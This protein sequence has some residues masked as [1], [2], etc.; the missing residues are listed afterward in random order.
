MASSSLSRTLGT[1]TDTKKWTNS[2]WWKPAIG[3]SQ[4]QIFNV[5]NGTADNTF[6]LVQYR[7]NAEIRLNGYNTTWLTTNRKFRDYSAWYHVVVVADSTES[8]ASNRLKLYINGTEETSF[9]TDNRASISQNQTWGINLAQPHFIGSE[10]GSG[11]FIEG[12]LSHIHFIDGTAYPA[13]TF[14]ETD[15][16]TGIWKAKT[17]PSVTYGTNGFFLKGENS[18]ALGTDS[19]GN[20]NNFTVN[21]TPTQTIDTPSNVFATGNPL[22][23]WSYNQTQT[24]G[25][26]SFAGTQNQWQGAS[27]TLGIS[28]GKYYFEAKITNDN[29]LSNGS[30]AMLIGFMGLDDYN[31]TN[32]TRNL[33]AHFSFDGG[34]IFVADATN[35][36]ATTADYGT[37]AT[38]DIMGVALDYDNEL[39]SYYKNGTA[40]VTNFNYGSATYPS[41]LKDGK[42]ITPVFVSYGTNAVSANFGNGFFGT[43][44]V[45]SATTDE[46]GLGIFEYTVPS[47]YYALCTKNINEQ[48]YS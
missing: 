26:T 37:F 33:V 23:R 34:E 41:T 1:A 15:A 12:L 16:T 19:S 20:G 24:N 30:T 45:A 27:S 28:K 21:G 35:T 47:G 38:N 9:A 3:G 46:S 6:F 48:E 13:S 43:T 29:G 11:S 4:Q 32:P 18:S 2:F 31:L 36:T 44:A 40:I 8:T 7:D 17:S 39:I 22:Y 42:T 10:G 5:S 14:G 25:N